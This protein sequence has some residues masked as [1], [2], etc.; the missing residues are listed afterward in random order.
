[1]SESQLDQL[2]RTLAEPMPR[3]RALRLAGM[4]LVAAAV[5]GLRPRT[6][7][8]GCGPDT[9]C[10]SLCHVPP[11]I[12]GCGVE[13]S[14]GCGSQINCRLSGGC[15]VAGD[16][17]CRG[18]NGATEDAWICPKNYRCGTSR[19]T[20]CNGG[21][22][23]CIAPCPPKYQCGDSC[24]KN[25]EYCQT[26]SVGADFCEKICPT[27]HDKCV[28]VCCTV[29]ETCGFFGCSCK[30]GFVSTG[31]GTCVPPK[32]DPGDPKPGWNPFSDMWNMMGQ[33]GAAHGGK[34]RYLM[35]VRHAQSGSAA[36]GTAL[37]ALAAVNGQGAAAMFAIR[38]GKQ[39]P[40]FTQ[41]VTVS[42]ATPPKLSADAG[43]DAGSVA[44]LNKL[45]VAEARAHALIGAMA[46]ALWR[47]R[48]A[49]AKHD[50]A[51]A[52]NQLRA[53]ATFAAQAVSALKGIQEL[54]K[55]AADALTA[56]GVSEVLSSAAEVTAFIASVRSRGLAGTLRLPMG[57]LG[58]GSADLK[59]LSALV[60]EQKVSAAVGPVLIAPLQDPARAREL[61]S[62][63]AELSKFS[64][65]ARKHPIA[66]GQG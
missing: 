65:R 62:L 23:G 60:L 40:A 51:A 30:S 52:K 37:G 50:N 4:A 27:G 48:A 58:V 55:R 17:C 9:P 44:A 56:G 31:A 14:T 26:Y 8:A 25:G 49:H 13:G 15:M 2:A 57:K 10:S 35:A 28:G 39:D 22:C 16:T 64:T 6:A 32:E 12:G 7:L 53:S 11:H 18:G 45:L 43:L 59:R 24:C 19:N 41:R 29:N 20:P 34:S 21:V 46:K 54:R 47:A 33:S 38:Y 5:P 61:K 3:R 66:T 36:V 42:P 1:M 63:I